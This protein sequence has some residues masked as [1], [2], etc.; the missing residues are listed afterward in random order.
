VTPFIVD[1]DGH[2]CE[3]VDLWE[4]RLSARLRERGPRVRWNEAEQCQQVLDEF[5]DSYSWAAAKLSLKPSEYFRRQCVISFDPGER[6][7]GA[8]ARLAGAGN[9][10]WASDFPHSD[11]RYPGVVDELREHTADM[12]PADQAALYGLNALRLYGIEARSG[13]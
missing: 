6:S 3:P 7:A 2:V 4:T 5:L 10:I 12:T 9:L 11:A 8:M 13:A 1:A